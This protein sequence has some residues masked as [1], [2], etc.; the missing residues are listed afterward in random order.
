MRKPAK[1]SQMAGIAAAAVLVSLPS[2]AQTPVRIGIGF[3]FGFLPAYIAD[4]LDLVE[5]HAKEAGLQA[6]AQYRRFSGSAAMQEA[7]QS[8]AIDMGV[9][10]VPG[11]LAAWDKGRGSAQQIVG[12][13]GVNSSPLVLVSNRPEVNTLADLPAGDKISMPAL[14]A[15]Q[16]LVLQMAAEKAFGPNQRDR[17]RAQVVALPHPDSVAALLSGTGDVRAYFSSPPFTQIAIESGKAKP[18]LSSQDVFGGR[19]SFLVLGATRAYADANAKMPEVMVKTLVEAAGIIRND[20]RKAAEIY[21]KFEPSRQLDVA[22]VEALLKAMADDFGIEVHGIKTYA[23]F[24]GRTGG[25]KTVPASF[26]D[27]FLPHLHAT[28]SN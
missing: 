2:L 26:K 24:M 16:M 19:A 1:L 4:E 11:I 21:L 5:K 3:G 23:D 25:L 15:P 12:L 9:Y 28:P 22:K 6:T 8:E 7:I 18:I 14:N 27:V 13:A 10:G 20:P 17:M